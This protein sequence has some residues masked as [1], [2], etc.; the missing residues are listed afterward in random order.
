MADSLP[1]MPEVDAQ[2]N[3]EQIFLKARQLVS[4]HNQG[5]HPDQRYIVLITPGRLLLPLAC[6]SPGTATAE[7]LQAVEN[8]A[9]SAH[10][11]QISVIAF[12]QIFPLND[13]G[14]ITTRTVLHV[15]PFLG[16]LLGLGYIG[17]TVT[18]FEGHPSALVAGCRDSD[19]L[20]VDKAMVPHLQKDWVEVVFKAMSARS[21]HILLFGRDNSISKINK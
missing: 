6:P 10:P 1:H 18:I 12:T 2:Q 20:V 16:Y 3:T 14:P 15:I 7:M 8:L 17:H 4:A 21:D 5:D 19:L 11:Q 9:P 13:Q